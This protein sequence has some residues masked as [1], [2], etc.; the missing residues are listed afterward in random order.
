[1]PNEHNHFQM[2]V[3]RHGNIEMTQVTGKDI[4]TDRAPKK[5]EGDGEPASGPG[6][7]IGLVQFLVRSNDRLISLLFPHVR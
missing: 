5:S 3:R 2:T 6:L 7:C 4:E 1:M